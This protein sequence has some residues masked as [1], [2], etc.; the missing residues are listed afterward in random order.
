VSGFFLDDLAIFFCPL[1][2]ELLGY[3]NCSGSLGS[4]PTCSIWN[5]WYE[6]SLGRNMNLSYCPS[7]FILMIPRFL[8]VLALTDFRKGF[9][10]MIEVFCQ[11]SMSMTMKSTKIDDLKPWLEHP[12]PF[13]RDV[14]LW[15]QQAPSTMKSESRDLHLGSHRPSWA[16]CSYL[17]PDCIVHNG[18]WKVQECIV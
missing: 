7:T 17:L 13:H 8:L 18:P 2:C 1:I 15:N 4:A 16:W 14:P 6:G 10:R 3:F 9:P 5:W 12:W 11:G